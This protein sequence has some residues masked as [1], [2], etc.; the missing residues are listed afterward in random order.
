[1][2]QLVPLPVDVES[3][4]HLVH[5][6]DQ[7]VLTDVHPDL[8]VLVGVLLEDEFEQSKENKCQQMNREHLPGIVQVVDETEQA[9]MSSFCQHT[10]A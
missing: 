2:G 7:D 9:V 1:M 3:N 4:I 6:H 10:V 8:L 5:Q